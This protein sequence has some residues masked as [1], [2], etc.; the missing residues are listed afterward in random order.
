MATMTRVIFC[1]IET[2]LMCMRP[3]IVSTTSR[4]MI[5]MLAPTISLMRRCSAGSVDVGA[6]S[7]CDESDEHAHTGSAEAE[8]PAH[9]LTEVAGDE[10]SDQ[11]T[12]VDAHVEN[13]ES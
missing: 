3:L 10:W 1:A 7:V 8:V 9:P 12:D 2:G 5:P 4:T 13:R 11:R 6:E